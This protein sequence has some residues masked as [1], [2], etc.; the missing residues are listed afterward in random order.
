MVREASFAETNGLRQNL[1]GL[2]DTNG[3]LR[4]AA[5]KR[6]IRRGS[7]A[8]PAGLDAVDDLVHTLELLAEILVHVIQIVRQLSQL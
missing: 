5:M 4:G 2:P 3:I 6:S 1:N 7:G 8:L